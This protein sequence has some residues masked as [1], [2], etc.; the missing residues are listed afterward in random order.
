M[1]KQD[2]THENTAGEEETL[3][4]PGLVDAV[5]NEKTGGR[6]FCF[7]DAKQQVTSAYRRRGPKGA[8]G[9]SIWYVPPRCA[10]PWLLPRRHE[11][12][13]HLKEDTNAAYFADL[14]TW[15]QSLVELP[16][17]AL[18]VLV[19]AWIVHTYIIDLLHA[20]PYLLLAGPPETGKSRILAAATLAARRGVLTMT[21]REA[22]LIRYADTFGATLGLDIVDF[23]DAIHS[24]TDYFAARTKNDGAVTTRILDYKK[25]PFEGIAHYRVFGATIVASNTGVPADFIASR[26][27]IVPASQSGRQFTEPVTPRL[28]L[29]FRER[30]IAFRARVLQLVAE[31]QLP[32]VPVVAT[33]RLGEIMGGLALAGGAVRVL[34]P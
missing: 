21:V 34:A 10:L 15:I 24:M 2:S 5:R 3:E 32:A 17:L 14:I 25:G 8:D 12:D 30:G 16:S 19:A 29:P 23:M 18:V 33:G 22:A 27:L 26:T 20:S 6:E 7:L 1:S 11:V 9:K 28:A 31:N 4:F 13:E